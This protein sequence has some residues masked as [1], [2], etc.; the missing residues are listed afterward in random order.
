MDVDQKEMML[1]I[2]NSESQGGDISL[3]KEGEKGKVGVEYLLCNSCPSLEGGNFD[4]LSYGEE[5]GLD[6]VNPDLGPMC[7]DKAYFLAKK[8][9]TK[10]ERRKR[11]DSL[12]I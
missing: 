4:G 10:K 9:Q 11:I 3:A 12:I 5:I 7:F 6:V 1:T 2:Q 8:K